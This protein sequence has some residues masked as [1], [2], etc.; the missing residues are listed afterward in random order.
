M[1]LD[2]RWRVAEG[3]EA[4]R[5]RFPNRERGV[6]RAARPRQARVCVSVSPS[7]TILLYPNLHLPHRFLHGLQWSCGEVN[8]HLRGLAG[9]EEMAHR[10]RRC[11]QKDPGTLL[12]QELDKDSKRVRREILSFEAKQ[13][14]SQLSL[15]DRLAIEQGQN[16][17]VHEDD[18]EQAMPRRLGRLNL[19]EYI[20]Y[21]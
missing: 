2:S 19:E 7:T 13:R 18:G 6:H 16:Q 11:N 15:Q 4:L 5:P 21:E 10:A 1:G 14:E 9:S 20:H 8:V 17:Q 12:V 3:M